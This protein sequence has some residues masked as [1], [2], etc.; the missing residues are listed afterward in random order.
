MLLIGGDCNAHISGKYYHIN[1]NGAMLE[2]FLQQYSILTEN[3]ISLKLTQ[4]LWKWRHPTGYLSQ[5]DYIIYR[6]RRR[7]IIRNS[8]VKLSAAT[9]TGHHKK[10][11]SK[12]TLYWHALMDDEKLGRIN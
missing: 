11:R 8:H 1:R 5:M 9:I 12:N 4:K 3:T 6:K 10:I 7:N 2:E